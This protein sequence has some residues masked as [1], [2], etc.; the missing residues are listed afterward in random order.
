MALRLF[1]LIALIVTTSGCSGLL[2]QIQF[3]G[4]SRQC[5]MEYRPSLAVDVTVWAQEGQCPDAE[6]RLIDVLYPS[7]NYSSAEDADFQPRWIPNEEGKCNFHT[8]GYS[9]NG[10]LFHIEFLELGEPIYQNY[11]NVA[12]DG[13]HPQTEG[14]VIDQTAAPLP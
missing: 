1:I 8:W 14:L 2:S 6:L 7:Q 3:G 10:G 13:C 9:S 11:V 4:D 5:T 12:H